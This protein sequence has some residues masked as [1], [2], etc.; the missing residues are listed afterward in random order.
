MLQNCFNYNTKGFLVKPTFSFFDKRVTAKLTK[1]LH[2]YKNLSRK[3]PTG[4]SRRANPGFNFLEKMGAPALKIMP[5]A[6]PEKG[7]KIFIV[8]W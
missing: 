3:K 1:R 6:Y 7:D 2:L 4:H 5:Y 8:D